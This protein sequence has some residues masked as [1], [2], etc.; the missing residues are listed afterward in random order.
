MVRSFEN[1]TRLNRSLLSGIQ[2]PLEVIYEHTQSI[3]IPRGINVPALKRSTEWHFTPESRLRVNSSL[4]GRSAD[5]SLQV[6]SHITG[7]DIFGTVPENQLIQHR[8]MMHP[9]GKGTVTY[10]APE[11]NYT[12]EV[13]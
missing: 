5:H 1:R 11:G 9:K 6:G 8:I 2:R 10:I 12:L 13:R 3:Y 7:G 4:S